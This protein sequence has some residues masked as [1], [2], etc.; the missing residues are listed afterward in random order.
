[1]PPRLPIGGIPGP[2]CGVENHFIKSRQGEQ[3]RLRR[4]QGKGISIE[5]KQCQIDM[6]PSPIDMNGRKLTLV[7]CGQLTW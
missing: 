6:S 7:D 5:Y 3:A 4:A 2:R 1:M